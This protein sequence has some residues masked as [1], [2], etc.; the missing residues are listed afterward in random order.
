[1]SWVSC[2][3]ERSGKAQWAGDVCADAQRTQ[4]ELLCG[5]LGGSDLDRRNSMGE[6]PATDSRKQGGQPGQGGQEGRRPSG[7]VPALEGLT[8]HWKG[9]GL[10]AE[11]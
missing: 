3:F 5:P 8:S 11:K 1:M 9:F 2:H 4:R 7:W 10:S 6:G